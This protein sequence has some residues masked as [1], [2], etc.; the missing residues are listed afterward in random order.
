MGFIK[1]KELIIEKMGRRG[2]LSAH[3]PCLSVASYFFPAVTR[4]IGRGFRGMPA[5]PTLTPDTRRTIAEPL[6][7]FIFRTLAEPVFHDG[8]FLTSFSAA[9]ATDHRRRLL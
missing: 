7:M 2:F 6:L 8:I 3:T 9:W 5:E 4:R 1:L